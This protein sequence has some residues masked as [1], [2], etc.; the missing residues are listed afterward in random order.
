MEVVGWHSSRTSRTVN[1]QNE[2]EL[3]Q[4][5]RE[6]QDGIAIHGSTCGPS[7]AGRAGVPQ[8]DLRGL[9]SAA[10]YCTCEITLSR[11]IAGS[12]TGTA[13]FEG[14]LAF[15]G[16]GAGGELCQRE[17]DELYPSKGD[18]M[19]ARLASENATH[20]PTRAIC[21]KMND[22]VI[23]ICLTKR[24]SQTRRVPEVASRLS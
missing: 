18:A 8:R 23:R 7:W 5:Q 15:R 12:N 13:R 22:P 16:R 20:M 10:D 11:K 14:D 3:K 19:R 6:D 1:F 9:A 17:S 24:F 2:E 4:V 21:M